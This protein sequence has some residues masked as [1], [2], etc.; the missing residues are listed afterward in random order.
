[1]GTQILKIESEIAEIIE[2]KVGNPHLEIFILL[3]H[4]GRK[5]IY[6]TGAN[7][8]LNYIRHFCM[9]FQNS[10]GYHVANFLNFVKHPQ[11]L[12]LG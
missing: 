12:H 3:V 11:L 5:N 8:S 4:H 9:D 1:M 10:C 6:L 7:F 2:V